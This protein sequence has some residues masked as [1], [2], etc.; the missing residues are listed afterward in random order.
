MSQLVLLVFPPPFSPTHTAH[1][2]QGPTPEGIAGF[3]Q[4]EYGFKE[5]K[6]TPTPTPGTVRA[7]GHETRSVQTLQALRPGRGQLERVRPS[8]CGVEMSQLGLLRAAEARRGGAGGTRRSQRGPARGWR[9]QGSRG[10]AGSR[11]SCSGAPGEP[12]P[13]RVLP[14]HLCCSGSG[15]FHRL[16][17]ENRQVRAEQPPARGSDS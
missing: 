14:H 12:S 17:E 1:R 7:R 3:I 6:N 2:R 11:G 5:G 16:G 8:S 4:D 15:I 9:G 10:A 13:P